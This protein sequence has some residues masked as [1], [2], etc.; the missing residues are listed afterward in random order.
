MQPLDQDQTCHAHDEV[1]G[2][3]LLPALG[4]SDLAHQSSKAELCGL[5]CCPIS[6]VLEPPQGCTQG[7][8]KGQRGNLVDGHLGDIAACQGAGPYRSPYSFPKS[9]HT[10]AFGL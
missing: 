7:R 5:E 2:K 10:L 1:I 6:A 4:T 3:V 8:G 9:G